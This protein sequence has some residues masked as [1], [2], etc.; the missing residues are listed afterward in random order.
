MRYNFRFKIRGLNVFFLLSHTQTLEGVTSRVGN[1]QHLI[2]W[3][4]EKCRLREAV[5]K[6]SGIQHEFKLGDIFVVSDAEQSFRGWCFSRRTWLEYLHILIHSFPLLDYGFFVWTIRR[7]S[8]TLRTSNKA[9][10]RSQKVVAVL[11]GYEKTEVP[12]RMTHVVYDTG[13][14][15]KGRSFTFG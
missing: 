1:N 8:S 5:E 15:K 11:K 9:G 2:F 14:L 6:L 12:S 4:L 3:D 10:R 7:G 13:I